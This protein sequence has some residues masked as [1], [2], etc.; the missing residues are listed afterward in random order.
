[1]THTAAEMNQEHPPGEMV[2]SPDTQAV[3]ASACMGYLELSDFEPGSTMVAARSWRL[4]EQGVIVQGLWS[5]LLQDET[6][7]GDGLPNH[8]NIGAPELCT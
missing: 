4:G 1:M 2:Q 8:G 5:L 6:S 3:C 7:P